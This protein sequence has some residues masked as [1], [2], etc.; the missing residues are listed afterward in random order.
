MDVY[1]RLAD[2]SRQVACDRTMEF[3]RFDALELSANFEMP[4][5]TVIPVFE[6]IMAAQT[7]EWAANRSGLSPQ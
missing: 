7:S 6:L 2:E 1:D 4:S 5:L 3:I